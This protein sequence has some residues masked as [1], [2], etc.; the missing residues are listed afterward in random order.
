M[1]SCLIPGDQIEAITS[2]VVSR[3]K[4]TV[5]NETHFIPWPMVLVVVIQFFVAISGS[6][7]PFLPPKHTPIPHL[8]PRHCVPSNAFTSNELDI[9]A[10]TIAVDQKCV[11]RR[12][13][14]SLS[15]ATWEG[16]VEGKLS[17]MIKSYP[18]KVYAHASLAAVAADSSSINL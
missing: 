2:Q 4:L 16:S 11:F 17:M 18:S 7:L 6:L 15:L 3:R 9:S 10:R 5:L 1:W 12:V 8:H 13:I 14:L